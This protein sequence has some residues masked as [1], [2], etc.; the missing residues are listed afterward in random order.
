MARIDAFGMPSAE[1]LNSIKALVGAG[2]QEIIVTIDNEDTLEDITSYSNT[3][4]SEMEV[5]DIDNGWEIH[6]FIGNAKNVTL[7]HSDESSVPKDAI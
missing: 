2:E 4:D 6:L 7:P 5:H 1:L 3:T